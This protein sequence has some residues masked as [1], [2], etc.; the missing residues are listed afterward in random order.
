LALAEFFIA[1]TEERAEETILGR[2]RP[3]WRIA[4][5]DAVCEAVID[6]KNRTPP[7]TQEGAA[8]VRTMNVRRGRFV[9]ANLA[10]TDAQSFEE[11]TKRGK[12]QRGDVLITRE[13]PI[14][15]VC[16]MPDEPVCLGQ[17]MMLY[18]PKQDELHPGYLL[19]ALQSSVVQEHLLRLAGG[20]T[21]G[22]V[23]V[24][25]IRHLP[26]PL[27][28]MEMQVTIAEAMSD[29]DSALDQSEATIGRLQATKAA[30]MV[31]L[32]SGRVRV[33]G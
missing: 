2:L 25:D 21:V 28:D 13:A 6:C 26:L 27:P 1:N 16:A 12:P 8:V 7:I 32:L 15:E 31:D 30:L 18:R 9:R 24:G 22:H 20:S 11:W 33:P 10:R 14:G 29:I 5:A 17:R 23:R 3:G 19:Y 4:S